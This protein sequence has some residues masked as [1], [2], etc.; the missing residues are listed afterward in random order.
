MKKLLM[1]MLAAAF[2]CETYATGQATG[3][4]TDSKIEAEM[5][6][7]E[8]ARKEMFARDEV[9]NP[10]PAKAPDVPTPVLKQQRVDVLE[11]AKQYEQQAAPAAKPAKPQELIVFVSFS[12]PEESLKRLAAQTERAGGVLVLRGFKDG[13]LKATTRAVQELGLAGTSFQINPP[14]FAKYKVQTVPTV[15]LT[16]PEAATQIDGE[17]CALADTY[18]SVAGDT[19]LDFALEAIGRNDKLFAYMAEQYVTKIRTSQ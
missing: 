4:P 2:A 5:T 9:K 17:G 8:Q 14:A 19:S 6:R 1:V 13:S 11:I 16:K 3:F 10:A 7:I 18:S 12:M 15:V